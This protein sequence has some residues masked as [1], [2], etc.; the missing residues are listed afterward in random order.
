MATGLFCLFQDRSRACL[1]QI[2]VRSSE[3]TALAAGDDSNSAAH[4]AT[5]TASAFS[6]G[7]PDADAFC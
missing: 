3:P 6:L 4:L 2:D 7:V 1:C 5:H